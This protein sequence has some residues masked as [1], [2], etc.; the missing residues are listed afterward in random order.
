MSRR[1]INLIGGFY[2]DSSLPWS[3]QD[4]V[5]WLPVPAQAEGTRSPMKLRGAPGL[6]GLGETVLVCAQAPGAA[7]RDTF[8]AQ[9]AEAT[10]RA[11][12]DGVY[13]S[14]GD[15]ATVVGGTVEF[16]RLSNTMGLV[17]D[18][19][20]AT[21]AWPFGG[22]Q[23]YMFL[24]GRGDRLMASRNGNRGDISLWDAGIA[25]SRL[26]PD[27]TAVASWAFGAGPPSRSGWFDDTHFY[28]AFT[29]SNITLGT[30]DRAY[31]IYKWP[32][33]GAGENVLPTAISEKF[34]DGLELADAS[35][36]FHFDRARNFHVYNQVSNVW[37][38]FNSDLSLLS[39]FSPPTPIALPIGADGPYYFHGGDS[40]LAPGQVAIFVRL[41]SDWSLVSEIQMPFLGEFGSFVNWAITFNDEV[42]VVQAANRA[43]TIPYPLVCAPA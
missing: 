32:T 18:Q 7:Q 13:A 24:G 31:R 2:K 43:V 8:E 42:I 37:R 26:I 29:R 5:N 15:V 6:R 14:S 16:K 21:T 38:V 34:N 39:S 17:A 35:F 23:R 40:T 10:I 41:K 19:A 28:L 36:L 11:D 27:L 30:D 20:I 3:A 22:D 33:S 1:E 4:T 12:E 25:R 9:F